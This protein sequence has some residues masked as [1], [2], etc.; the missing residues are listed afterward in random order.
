MAE[1]IAL[2]ASLGGLSVESEVAI[3][4]KERP[5]D[6][7]IKPWKTMHPAAVDVTIVHP[8]TNSNC[9]LPPSHC[10]EVLK[11]AEADKISHYG[12]LCRN[13]ILAGFSTFGVQGPHAAQF[14]GGLEQ[15]TITKPG[16]DN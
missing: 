1:T 6:L 15:T 5:A 2:Q 12:E 11:T 16:T 10:S 14:I 13:A 7:L 9:L 4:G 8:L 3:K